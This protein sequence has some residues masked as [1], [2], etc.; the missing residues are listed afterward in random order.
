MRNAFLLILTFTIY[1]SVLYGENQVTPEA[2]NG[3]MDI[4]NWDFKANGIIKLNGEWDF[5]WDTLVNPDKFEGNNIPEP[6]KTAI[7]P[8]SWTSKKGG[9]HITKGIATY[10]LKL[11]TGDLE[12]SYGIRLY[13]I[14]TSSRVWFD[15]KLIYTTGIV[16]N[17]AKNS[18]PGF[19]Y[20]N[21]PLFLD[22]Q[23]VSH[24]LVVQTANFF[25]T[26]AGIIKPVFFGPYDQLAGQSKRILIINMIIVGIILI[27]SFNHLLYF[28]LRKTDRSNLYFGLLCFVMILR[29][30]STDS[31]IITFIFPGMNWELLFKLDNFSGFGTI[32]LFAMFLYYL[33]KRE[34]P[35]RV[36][37]AMVSIG[38]I[39]TLFV[40]STPQIVYGRFRMFYEF[41]ILFGGLYL[42]FGVLLRASF[43]KREGALLTFTGF[44]ILY[45][46]AINDVLVSMGIAHTPDLA[47]YGLVTYMLIQSYILSRRSASAMVENE[48]L[49]TAL[50]QEKQ[51][52]EDRVEQRTRELQRQ[53]DENLKHKEELQIQGWLNEGLTRVNAILNSNKDNLQKLSQKLIAE[54]VNIL[55]AHIGAIYLLNEI[56][57]QHELQLS[58]SWNASREMLE[59]KKII[60]G[61][62]LVGACF[63]DM[64]LTLLNDIPESF[65]KLSS[66]LGEAAVKNLVL[67]PLKT[68]DMTIGVL[69][70][71]AFSAFTSQQLTFLEKTAENISS[72][73]QF[74]QMNDKNT[75]LLDAF[76]KKENQ[77]NQQEE[78]L[79]FHLEELRS[80]REEVETYR[81]KESRE[82]LN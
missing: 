50:Q 19:T 17:S 6:V 4:R 21:I 26:R 72:T 7:V 24:E 56:E 68:N 5:Y 28:F 25:H 76:T 79:R 8:S 82:N 29:N 13:D 40:F 38:V 35:R 9:K 66:G 61:E 80:L 22:K 11:E 57:E 60:S 18:R 64:K 42:T 77:L 2:V 10:R 62:G 20:K 31:R 34:F 44:F 27:I 43:H 32:P 36:L 63:K 52:L 67:I 37:Y 16:G 55:K 51:M 41:Y 78:E 70:I 14:F 74:L 73:I 71:A 46:T 53:N 54:I 65:I 58:G 81:K 30:I 23:S 49:S 15:N 48:H 45:G 12:G 39:I 69:E 59:E 3:T 47:P 1:S 33:F 75:R